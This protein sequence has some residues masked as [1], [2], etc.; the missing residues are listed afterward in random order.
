MGEGCMD[1]KTKCFW[2]FGKLFDFELFSLTLFYFAFDFFDFW[3]CFL[4][5]ARWERQTRSVGQGF[6][7]N[8]ESASSSLIFA[9]LFCSFA[10][11][12]FILFAQL[13]KY[14][15]I[16]RLRSMDWFM[17]MC[18]RARLGI[19][20]TNSCNR[21]NKITI[22]KFDYMTQRV[23]ICINDTMK[24]EEIYTRRYNSA[25]WSKLTYGQKTP[26]LVLSI[27]RS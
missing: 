12:N 14:Q 5:F 8:L 26:Y 17:W 7:L 24:E 1:E 19:A 21:Q 16:W 11:W 22:I 13:P 25:L 9:L 2:C 15:G 27:E 18:V 10:I 23:L 3:L 4:L 20:W 6:F